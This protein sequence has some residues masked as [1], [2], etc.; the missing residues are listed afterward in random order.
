MVWYFVS[1]WS[2]I[3]CQVWLVFSVGM[4]RI[5]CRH[6]LPFYV[7]IGWHFVSAWSAFCVGIA[8]HFVWHSLAFCVGIHSLAFLCRHSL[9]FCSQARVSLY[10]PT[11]TAHCATVCY[12]LC[13]MLFLCSYCAFI[14]NCH[15]NS[16]TYT[17]LYCICTVM[18]TIHNV[19]KQKQKY[20]YQKKKKK[21][22]GG[23]GWV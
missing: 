7:G 8:W 15:K 1:A 20:I 10:L 23:G 2:G 11:P 6:S 14:V 22:K 17:V 4:V 13:F 21:K 5:L 19:I 12:V 18:H 9:A 3:L 16:T